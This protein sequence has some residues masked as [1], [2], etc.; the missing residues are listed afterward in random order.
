MARAAIRIDHAGHLGAIAV[1]RKVIRLVLVLV[2]PNVLRRFRTFVRAIAGHRSPAELHRQENHEKNEK[3]T[4]HRG[5]SVAAACQCPFRMGGHVGTR[6]PHDDR[7]L[8]CRT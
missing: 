3:P 8:P 5:A 2:V 6:K 1:S 7:A 4:A